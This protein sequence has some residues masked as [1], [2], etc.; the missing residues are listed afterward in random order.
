MNI[1]TECAPLFD[2]VKFQTEFD[3]YYKSKLKEI[4]FPE[5]DKGE[6]P[7]SREMGMRLTEALVFQRSH[8]PLIDLD[9]TCL[10]NTTHSSYLRYL[11]DLC[12]RQRIEVID[13]PWRVG[14]DFFVDMS[15]KRF[16]VASCGYIG[17]DHPDPRILEFYKDK[18]RS[19]EWVEKEGK[20]GTQK[21]YKISHP[22]YRVKMQK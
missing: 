12:L 16:D 2:K 8:I 11:S 9:H 5:D 4:G 3:A 7:D 20:G 19:I 21:G 15:T 14:R 1:P 10:A 22:Y 17:H 18:A 13:F 6:L